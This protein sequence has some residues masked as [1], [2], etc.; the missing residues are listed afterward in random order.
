M[1]IPLCHTPTGVPPPPRPTMSTCNI[2]TLSCLPLSR[3]EHSPAPDCQAEGFSP[4][5]PHP[6]QWSIPALPIPSLAARS[7]RHEATSSSPFSLPRLRVT[8]PQTAAPAPAKTHRSQRGPNWTTDRARLNRQWGRGLSP[9]TTRSCL[10][11]LDWLQL[12]CTHNLEW[13]CLMYY[14]QFHSQI[15]FHPSSCQLELE[16]SPVTKWRRRWRGKAVRG[17]PLLRASLLRRS[18]S[19]KTDLQCFPLYMCGREFLI[20]T[21]GCAF[22]M[23]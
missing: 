14:S 11:F 15:N 3:V 10:V 12:P 1:S 9:P 17:S 23:E 18:R 7:A 5:H 6:L 19:M 20:C 4:A 22:S 16:T 8:G 13:D 2:W 21:R